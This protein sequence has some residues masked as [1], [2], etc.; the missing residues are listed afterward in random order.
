MA[1]FKKIAD[2][3]VIN[4]LNDDDNVVIIGSD[5]ALKQT[6]SSNLGMDIT[7]TEVVEAP[8]ENDTLVVVSEGVVKQVPAASFA[9]GKPIRLRTNSDSD[10][11]YATDGV[12]VMFETEEVVTPEVAISFGHEFTNGTPIILF[13]PYDAAICILV[14]IVDEHPRFHFANG[15]QFD[16]NVGGAPS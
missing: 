10:Y 1:E 14:E 9:A 13:T 3:D 11:L 15:I 7:K 5:G 16:A 12:V 4:T 8:A 2:V 6:S